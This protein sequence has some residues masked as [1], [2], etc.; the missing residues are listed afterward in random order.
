MIWFK[1]LAWVSFCYGIALLLLFGFK[2]SGPL[3]VYLAAFISV[4]GIFI[5]MPFGGMHSGSAS[6]WG[7]ILNWCFY[8]ALV[9]YFLAGNRISPG[10]S[11]VK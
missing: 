6:T 7:V 4:P 10:Q 9:H 3:A 2:F 1:A 5:A 8:V 11:N